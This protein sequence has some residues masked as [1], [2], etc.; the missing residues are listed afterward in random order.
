MLKQVE[1]EE[2]HR[3]VVRGLTSGSSILQVASPVSP[4]W[5]IEARKDS[6]DSPVGLSAPRR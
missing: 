3:D 2:T 4:N 6:Q 1:V 5:A